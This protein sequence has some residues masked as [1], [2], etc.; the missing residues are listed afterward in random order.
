MKD[1]IVSTATLSLEWVLDQVAPQTRRVTVAT[2]YFAQTFLLPS[3]EKGATDAALEATV[4]TYCLKSAGS[5]QHWFRLPPHCKIRDVI[6]IIITVCHKGHWTVADVRPA[7]RTITWHDSLQ[8]SVLTL[9][10]STSTLC[11]SAVHLLT[12]VSCVIHNH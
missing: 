1:D 3:A 8:V 4:R 7:Q 12:S 2:P 6:C 9:T 10:C 11:L 5:V